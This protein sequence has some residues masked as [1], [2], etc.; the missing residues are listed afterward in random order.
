MDRYRRYLVHDFP[1]PD[2]IAIENNFTIPSEGI[3]GRGKSR[4]KMS[5]FSL[6]LSFLIIYFNL[7]L[8]L[9]YVR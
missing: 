5:F 6:S 3:S 1:L 9:L 2:S 7:L 8:R 4:D